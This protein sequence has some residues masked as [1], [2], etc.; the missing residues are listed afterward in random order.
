MYKN[1]GR[2]TPNEEPSVFRVGCSPVYAALCPRRLGKVGCCLGV[3]RVCGSPP[4]LPRVSPSALIPH[5]CPS[6]WQPPVCPSLWICLCWTFHIHGITQH[7]AFCIYQMYAFPRYLNCG[8]WD[9]WLSW[10]RLSSRA[11]S[12]SVVRRGGLIG[13]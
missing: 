4:G 8:R 11:L 1:W 9:S 5:S 10:Q 6:P 3:R 13:S 2:R 12:A 7:V